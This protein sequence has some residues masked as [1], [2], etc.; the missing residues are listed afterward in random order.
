M[1]FPVAL[2]Q[3]F[4]ALPHFQRL[5]ELIPRHPESL[6]YKGALLQ[7]FGGPP[8]SCI[9]RTGLA[10]ERH[11]GDGFDGAIVGSQTFCGE[12]SLPVIERQITAGLEQPP[13]LAAVGTDLP[14][15]AAG[16]LRYSSLQVAGLLHRGPNVSV[17]RFRPPR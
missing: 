9:W 6:F 15:S 13:N 8:S 7:P 2:S 17:S 3:Y 5:H 10:E 16:L 14:V 1:R 4:V 11:T 12:L